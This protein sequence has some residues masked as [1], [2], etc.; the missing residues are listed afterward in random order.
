LSCGDFFKKSRRDAHLGHIVAVA[1]AVV[2]AGEDERVHG[3]RHADVAEAALFFKLVGAGERARMREKSLF[4][5]GEKD[6]R[7]FEALGGVQRHERDAS[8]GIELIGVGGECGVV[9]EFGESFAALFGIVRGVGQ[10][11]QIFNA[12]EGL[13]RAFGLESFD[14]AGAVDDEA[15]ELGESGGVAGGAKCA[16]R[17]P[18]LDGSRRSLQRISSVI[19]C[20][21][22]LRNGRSVCSRQ[23]EVRLVEQRNLTLFATEARFDVF[24]L[25]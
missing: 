10:F 2:G 14:V 3:A 25:R 13:G 21:G 20:D 11:L 6:Q 23:G 15:D 5:A 18:L 12:A 19:R 16:P 4:K 9:E 7:E 8:V 22:I 24:T 17:F 1:A